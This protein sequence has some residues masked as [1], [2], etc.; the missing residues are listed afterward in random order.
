MTDA[1]DANQLT[2]Y[3]ILKKKRQDARRQYKK[4]SVIV[5]DDCNLVLVL[6]ATCETVCY[7]FYIFTTVDV[8]QECVSTISSH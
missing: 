5:Y 8:G 4:K 7:V 6:K 1:E 2:L 3:N